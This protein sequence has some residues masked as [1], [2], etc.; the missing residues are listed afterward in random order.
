MKE[1]R[2]KIIVIL[3]ALALSVYLLW[4]TY[5]DYSNNKSITEIV[6]KKQEEIKRTYPEITKQDLQK[7]LV[8]I[9]DSIRVSDPSIADARQKRIKLGLDLQGGM[10]VVLEV[11][12]GRLLEKLAKDPDQTFKDAL[13]SA[14]AEA[15]LSNEPVVDILARNFEEKG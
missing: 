15:A 9:E 8:A 14:Q 11:N 7:K 10:R 6:S 3:A 4:P 13:N 12:T 1:F 5:K 2:F